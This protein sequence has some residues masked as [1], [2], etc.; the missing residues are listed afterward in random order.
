MGRYLL[1]IC[2]NLGN[3]SNFVCTISN[4][5]IQCKILSERKTCWEPNIVALTARTVDNILLLYLVKAY[6]TMLSR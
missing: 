6:F 2:L 3:N 1:V 4:I 5:V